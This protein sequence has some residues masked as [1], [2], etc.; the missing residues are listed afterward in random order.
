MG[1]WL[2][3]S[4]S[5]VPTTAQVLGHINHDSSKRYISLNHSGLKNCSL[6]LSGIAVSKEGLI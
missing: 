2:V 4:G 5:D 6:G 1:T 3:E